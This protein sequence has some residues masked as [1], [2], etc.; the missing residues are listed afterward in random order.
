M[1]RPKRSVALFC[2]A[3]IALASFL[4]GISALDHAWFELEWVLLPDE[5][6][7]LVEDPLPAAGERSLQLL[8]LLPSRAPPAASLA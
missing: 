3:V 4:P 8:S 1:P 2:V 7:V 6:T 5:S